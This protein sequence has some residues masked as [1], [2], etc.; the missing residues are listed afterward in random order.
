MVYLFYPIDSSL[1]LF[2]FFFVVLVHLIQHVLYKIYANYKVNSV[3]AVFLE[4][5][6][7]GFPVNWSP[8]Y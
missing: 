5:S 2:S 8:V 3:T 1:L 6:I 7:F 4:K